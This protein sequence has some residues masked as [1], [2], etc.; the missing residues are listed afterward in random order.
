MKIKCEY[1]GSFISDTDEKCPNC[2]GTNSH[3]AR[4]AKGVP[5]TI[6]ELKAFCAERK[7]PLEKMRFF[8]GV[9]YKKPKAFG[10]YEDEDGNFVVYKNKADGSRAVR[11]SGKDEAYA[12]NEIFQKLRSEVQLRKKSGTATAPDSSARSMYKKGRSAGY[13]ICAVFLAI[14]LF[15]GIVVTYETFHT[16]DK[17]Y[18]EYCGG[19][20]YNDYD[21]WYYYDTGSNSWTPTTVDTQLSDNYGDYWLSVD[22]SA[23]YNAADFQDS[24]YY[25]ATTDEDWSDDDWDDDDFDYDYDSW[26]SGSTDWDSDW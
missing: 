12:V 9:D 5:K 8:L 14:T 24:Q 7:M 22:Y 4:S 2:G 19:C 25:S 1:C 10:I 17:G 6:A 13:I 23:D 16:P 20:Y 3:L 26:D 15:F 21:S 11:Y 18:Y